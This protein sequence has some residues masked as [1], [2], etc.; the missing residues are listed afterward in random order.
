MDFLN[1][2]LKFL[3]IKSV[4][5]EGNEEAINF[6]IPFFEQAGAKLVLQ[7]VPHSLKDH[8]KRQYNLLAIFGDDLVDS[9]TR[10]GLLLAAPVDTCFPGN[11]PDWTEL[12]GNPFKP[13]NNGEAICGLG[14]ANSKLNFLAMLAAADS[15]A[16][17][18]FQRPL[19]V[20]ATCGGESVLPGC[21]Y[22][23]QSGAVNPKHV[24]VGRP[25][26]LRLQHTEKAQIVFQLRISFIAVERDA[27]EF[28]AKVF[29]SSRSQGRHSSH[30]Q[31]E[32]NAL[33][34]VLFFLES[35][36]NSP[37]ENKLMLVHGAGSL[38]RVPDSASAG[39]VIRSKDLDAI[40]DRFRSISANNRDCHFEMRLG[41]TGDRGVRLLPEEVYAA[42]RKLLD[43]IKA[44][45]EAMGPTRDPAFSPDHSQAILS[46]LVHERDALDLTIQFQLL[47]EFA[48]PE[49]RK[50]IEADF[51]ARVNNL[52]QNY[53]AVSL[54][55]RRVH[56]TQRFFTD[57]NGTFM[58]TLR[59]DMQRAG[60]ADSV[61]PGNYATEAA[62]FSE[63]GYE[64]IAFGAGS[65]TESNCP[66]E[67]VKLE[68]LHSAVRFYSRA[69]EAFCLRGI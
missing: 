26:G 60:L 18:R 27:Q 21:R 30:P 23:I 22:L 46:S 41:G 36:K 7:Q 19:Y 3:E 40:R 37:I 53:R 38:N 64:A 32:K 65:I 24:I 63:R 13:K 17:S 34:N 4:A 29:V 1:Q 20:A 33:A 14:A 9:R 2:A 10:K 50:E 45:N 31:A 55:C 48:S 47:P 35:L 66:N 52:A 11:A 16:R 69:I 61:L 67:K 43:E 42:L 59:A 68:E 58:T 5:E 54:E 44:M 25:T 62:L 57:P 15:Y 8:S 39:V 56:A 28:N 51:K 12:G 6:L 49:A